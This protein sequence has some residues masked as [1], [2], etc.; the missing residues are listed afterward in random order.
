MNTI[1][2]L[3][4]V[5]AICNLATAANKASQCN[6]CSNHQMQQQAIQ[7]GYGFYNGGHVYV[8]N[9]SE[10]RMNKYYTWR[11][12]STDPRM[13]FQEMTAFLESK[14]IIE[15]SIIEYFNS[16]EL[17]IDL[18]RSG[19]VVHAVQL[20]LSS[21]EHSDFR[22]IDSLIDNIYQRLEGH[23]PVGNSNPVTGE[24]IGP[25][26]SAYQVIGDRVQ[27]IGLLNDIAKG[28][29]ANALLSVARIF[30]SVGIDFIKITINFPDGSTGVAVLEN[31]KLVFD[32]SSWIDSEGNNIP[33]TRQNTL[34]RTYRFQ[35]RT[36]PNYQH[37]FNRL[38]ELGV[39]INNNTSNGIS[40][41]W[42]CRVDGCTLSCS[43][44]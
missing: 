39:P 9:F 18:L 17:K 4:A 5:F 19:F 20:T 40:C 25:T 28:P 23:I 36:S 43:T 37:F 11:S 38:V 32:E 2:Y 41:S 31:G 8:M 33:L 35:E 27:G 6:H 29:E 3:L 1:R 10:H 44:H 24:L 14:G 12:T 30:Q 13:S 21:E 16:E 42:R 26:F 22:F 7:T 15:N 34:G